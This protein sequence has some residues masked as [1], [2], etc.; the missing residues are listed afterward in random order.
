MIFAD[1][2]VKLYL[3]DVGA[4]PLLSRWRELEV[5]QRIETAQVAL[6]RAL[7]GVDAAIAVLLE[8]EAPLRAG[9]I[10]VADVLALPDGR[11]QGPA[12]RAE[13]LAALA[14]VR[15]LA[16]GRSK[17]AARRE[18]GT[19]LAALPLARAL[20]DRMV[21]AALAS[22]AAR[23]EVRARAA[24]E[25]RDAE[26]RRAKRDLMEGNL[27]LVVSV[28]KRYV[29]TGVAF[30]D[31]IQEG[32]VGLMRAVDRFQYRRGFRFSTYATWW[33]RQAITRAIADQARTVRLPV[34]LVEV[35]NRMARV[36][37]E[38]ANTLGRE[39]TADELGRLAGVAP[40]KV[41]LLQQTA[42]RP[43]AL[44]LPVG[45]SSR[46]G[47]FLEDRSVEPA[48]R[49]LI[50]DELR[51]Y[52]ERALVVLSAKERAIVQMRFGLD[53]GPERTLEEVGRRFA[54][55]RERV[56]QIEV[57]ALRKLRQPF[58]GDGLRVFLER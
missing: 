20:L 44:E 12:E 49:R 31:L 48:D 51:A 56:R 55:C 58:R 32:N 34:H 25:T 1:D 52:L 57:K 19:V 28:A 27:R 39:P 36:Q 5:C 24:V 43:V 30:P 22:P 46:F 53:G 10:D 16:R 14:R 11:E 9:R 47:D 33:I 38:L 8:R 23:G 3:R 37:R 21:T 40:A 35:S 50:G 6:R 42:L 7:G 29:G 17:V 15:R 26:V 13:A 18:L 41:R 45:D 54:V 4:V 2:A